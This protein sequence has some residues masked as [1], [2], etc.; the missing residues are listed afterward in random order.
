MISSLEEGNDNEVNLRTLKHQSE[1]NSRR[2]TVLASTVVP[3][4]TSGL[5]KSFSL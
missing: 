1:Q 3:F 2:S 5:A 4:A